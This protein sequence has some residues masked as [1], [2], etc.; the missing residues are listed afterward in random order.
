MVTFNINIGRKEAVFFVAFF[1]AILSVG[2]VIAYNPNFFGG[3]PSEFGHSSGEV[4]VKIGATEKTLQA[5]IDDGD[6]GGGFSVPKSTLHQ[7]ISITSRN[8]VDIQIWGD[9]A[10]RMGLGSTNL[11][12]MRMTGYKGVDF[13]KRNGKQA[14][15]ICVTQQEFE[16]GEISDFSG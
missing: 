1:A 12:F 3:V 16:N 2:A 6:F 5:A 11:R 4:M 7:I 15:G 9:E 13:G 14:S 10:C 8:S